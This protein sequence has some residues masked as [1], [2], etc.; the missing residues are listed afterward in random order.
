LSYRFY[1]SLLCD[2]EILVMKNT[3]LLNYQDLV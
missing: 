1:H 2:N 3:L